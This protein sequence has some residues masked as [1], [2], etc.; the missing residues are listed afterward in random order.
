MHSWCLHKLC[1]W[2][3]RLDCGANTLRTLACTPGALIPKS[4]AD[5]SC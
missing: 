4:L 5:K 3:S 1:G 2:Q